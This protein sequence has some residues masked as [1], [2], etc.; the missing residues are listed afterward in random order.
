MPFQPT[1]T[2][3]ADIG[4]V[5]TNLGDAA[6]YALELRARP[7]DQ[8]GESWTDDLRSA[9]DFIN[10]MDRIEAALAAEARGRQPVNEGRGGRSLGAPLDGPDLRSLGQRVV[11]SEGFGDWQANGGRQRSG[12]FTTEVRTLIG[13]FTTGAFDTNS[14]TWLPVN[15]RELLT[16]TL[17]RRRPFLRDLLGVQ[18]T[19]LASFAYMREQLATTTETGAA[20]TSEA[21]AKAEVDMLFTPADAPARK[22]TAWIPVTDEML[23]DAPTLRGYID[24]R[25]E[26]MLMIREEAQVYNGNGT[27]P[28]LQGLKGVSGVQTQT[29]VSGDFPATI[30]QAIAKVE[31]VDG[32]ADGVACNPTD[33]WV[34]ASKRYPNQFDNGFGGGAPGAVGNITWGVPAVRTR[35]LASGAA[36]VAAWRM[37]ATIFEREGTTIKVGDQHSDNFVKNITVILAEKRVALPIWRPDYF[38]DTTVPTS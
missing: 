11:D 34:A 9:I 12:A 27:A 15:S 6:R 23:S 33:Y 1:L 36:M 29:A 10:D 21:S 26:Y 38:V 13:S 17:Q 28:N 16:P 18:P 30:A 31:T 8:R 20:M 22:I 4:A 3:D 14:D 32:D 24:A 37:G 7:A 35:A 5:R 2:R 19:G 25:L